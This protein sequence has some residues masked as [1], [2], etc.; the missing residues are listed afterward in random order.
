MVLETRRK[1]RLVGRGATCDYEYVFVSELRRKFR[2]RC[3]YTH[4]RRPAHGAKCNRT[5]ER[6]AM[7]SVDVGSNVKGVEREVESPCSSSASTL[8][9]WAASREVNTAALAPGNRNLAA[10]LAGRTSPNGPPKSSRCSKMK[11]LG[12][13]SNSL[14]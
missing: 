7:D 6:L 4:P 12:C 14:R 9:G 8:R 13:N 5:P 2:W 1:G 3:C 10:A 11:A